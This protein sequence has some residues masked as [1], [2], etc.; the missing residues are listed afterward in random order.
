MENTKSRFLREIIFRPDMRSSFNQLLAA[1]ASFDL[2]YL[3]TMLLEGVSWF[4]CQFYVSNSSWVRYLTLRIQIS[5]KFLSIFL[6]QNLVYC[7]FLFTQI[8][9]SLGG[10]TFSPVSL[11]M[12]LICQNCPV[13]NLIRGDTK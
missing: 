12:L 4:E 3:F 6:D 7:V 13:R 1:L 2:L 8:C 5:F 9:L 10:V 11:E